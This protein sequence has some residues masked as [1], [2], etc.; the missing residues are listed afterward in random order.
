MHQRDGG[1]Q[2]AIGDIAGVGEARGDLVAGEGHGGHR[3]I[4]RIPLRHDAQPFA[5]RQLR[6]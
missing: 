1:C 5:A 6:Q 4:N 2:F 3:R